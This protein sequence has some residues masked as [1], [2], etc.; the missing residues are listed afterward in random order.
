MEINELLSLNSDGLFPGPGES[1][2]DF[3]ERVRHVQEKLKSQ[4]Q[5]VALHH[6]Q[7]AAEQ[8]RALYDFSP[9]WCSAYYSSKGLA[10][11]QAAAT[12]IDVKRVYSIQLRQSGWISSLVSRDE[13]LAHEAVHAARAAFDEPKAEEMFAYLT[14]PA[15]WRQVIGPLFRRPIE[16]LWFMG[17]IFFGSLLQIAEVFWDQMLGSSLCFFAAAAFLFGCSIRLCGMR[18]RLTRAA[19]QLAPRLRDPAKVRAVLFRLADHEIAAL[20]KGRLST[21]SAELRWQLLR[22]QY[23]K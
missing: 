7:W 2:A 10:P 13:V 14:S 22:S 18:V 23:F 9:K 21:D 16:A 6:W 5:P 19:K 3:C 4:E 15:K 1:E 17:L 8:L 12:W 11:W 20:S